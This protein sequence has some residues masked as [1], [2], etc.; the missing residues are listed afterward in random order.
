MFD[1]TLASLDVH[2]LASLLSCFVPVEQSQEK[3]ALTRVLAGP[4]GR[5]QEAARRVA[6]ASTACGLPLDA[7]EYCEAF[8]PTL[9]DVVYLW[10]RG[11]PFSSVSQRTDVFE[12]SLV[13]A[14]RRLDELMQQLA[15]AAAAVGDG[16]L[17]AHVD[18]SAA[19]LRRGVMFAASLYI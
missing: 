3:V 11:E 6:A 4:L 17:R 19:T 9:M 16:Q 2:P 12:G 7:E 1:G 10:S 8:R 5:L 13:R 14:V 15:L 18:A